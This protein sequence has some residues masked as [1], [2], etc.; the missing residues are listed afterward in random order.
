MKRFIHDEQPQEFYDSFNSFIIS[1]DLKLFSKL[2]S[3][4]K[5]VELVKD[6]PGDIVELGVFKGSG[7]FAWLKIN[8][9]CNINS[10]KVYGFDAF[11]IDQV[12]SNLDGMQRDMMSNL[13][14]QRSFKP[15][16]TS[17]NYF[18]FLE[19]TL[20]KCGFQNC[21][22][23][24]G[25][26]LDTIPK[27]VKSNPGFRASI[28]NFDLDND[29]PTFKC[30]ESLWDRITPGGIAIFD[31]Y[32]VNQ[33]DESNAVDRFLKNKDIKLISTGFQAPTAYLIKN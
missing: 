9:L 2:Y 22:L 26:V 29:K 16:D 4:F 18:S 15:N 21:H 24:K 32:A 27:F 33:W 12:L 14:S 20:E 19:A 23:I 1:S 31:E 11:D 5:L 13:F 17:I 10:K 30:L 25:D 8:A 3:K 28:V 6:I 7:L